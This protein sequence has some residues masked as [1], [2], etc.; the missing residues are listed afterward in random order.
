[1]ADESGSDLPVPTQNSP[2]VNPT[3]TRVHPTQPDLQ[4]ADLQNSLERER[5]NRL[6]ERWMWLAAS[7]LLFV[8]LCFA[9]IDAV[10]GGV[11]LIVYLSVLIVL[12]KRW[13]IDNVLET[14]AAVHKIFGGG[15]NKEE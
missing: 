4:V 3:L 11:C 6:E 15:S 14:L 8:M 9:A 2:L 10:A 1:M 5:E 13:G 7:G 12:G